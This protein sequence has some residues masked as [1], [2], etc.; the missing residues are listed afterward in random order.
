M[1]SKMEKEGTKIA[2]IIRDDVKDWRK[3]YRT[4]MDPQS[5]IHWKQH[6]ENIAIINENGFISY[7]SQDG[8]NNKDVIQRAFLSLIVEEKKANAFIDYMHKHTSFLIAKETECEP[9]FSYPVT[10]AKTNFDNNK[11]TY[12]TN[13]PLFPQSSIKLVNEIIRNPLEMLNY[14]IELKKPKTARLVQVECIDPVWGRKKRLFE[15]VVSY[16]RNC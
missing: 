2:H 11:N 14:E 8:I 3:N 7:N 15:A 5:D 12:M 16:I 13:I 4:P 9:S 6:W 1:F 10:Y